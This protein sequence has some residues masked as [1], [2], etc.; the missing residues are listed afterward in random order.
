M[1]LLIPNATQSRYK[2]RSC[3]VEQLVELP[4][5]QG[6]WTSL[7]QLPMKGIPRQCDKLVIFEKGLTPSGLITSLLGLLPGQSPFPA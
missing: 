1:S 6:I 2:D 5:N 7:S 3:R 4:G